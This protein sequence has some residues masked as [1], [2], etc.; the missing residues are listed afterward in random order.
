MT[1]PI[2]SPSRRPQLM[3]S[4]KTA[5]EGAEKEGAGGGTKSDRL[6]LLRLLLLLLLLL[7]LSSWSWWDAL[8]CLFVVLLMFAALALRSRSVCGWE[9]VEWGSDV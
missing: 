2:P 6:P 8:I 4:W 1:W 7:L 9:V 5:A 3:A